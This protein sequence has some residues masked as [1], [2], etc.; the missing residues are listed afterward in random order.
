[1]A[2]LNNGFSA[3]KQVAHEEFVADTKAELD[4]VPASAIDALPDIPATQELIPTGEMQSQEDAS[5]ILEVNPTTEVVDQS[6][7]ITPE[8]LAEEVTSLKERVGQLEDQLNSPVVQKVIGFQNMLSRQLERLKQ[9]PQ[10]AT[11]KVDQAL[12][13]AG[14]QGEKLAGR[15][16]EYVSVADRVLKYAQAEMDALNRNSNFRVENGKRVPMSPVMPAMERPI[17]QL[18][19]ERPLP[20]ISEQ[21]PR[22]ESV[23]AA[24]VAA[25]ETV[26]ASVPEDEE[27]PSTEV[28]AEVLG[29]AVTQPEQIAATNKSEAPVSEERPEQIVS[30]ERGSERFARV[31]ELLTDPKC[32]EFVSKAAAFVKEFNLSD[33]ATLMILAHQFGPDAEIVGAL[34]DHTDGL[35]FIQ[36]LTQLDLNAETAANILEDYMGGVEGFQ[37]V[38]SPEERQRAEF[39]ELIK[40]GEGTTNSGLSLAAQRYSYQAEEARLSEI[41]Q[42]GEVPYLSDRQV[43]ESAPGRNGESNNRELLFVYA[44]EQSGQAA[45]RNALQHARLESMLS[46]QIMIANE[47]VQSEG[48]IVTVLQ[49]QLNQALGSDVVDV[50][51]ERDSNGNALT[52]YEPGKTMLLTDYS[53]GHLAVKLIAVRNPEVDSRQLSS[54]CKL[55]L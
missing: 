6:N 52:K 30:N 24:T 3:E 4:P 23:P 46:N 14:N 43:K 45:V 12:G 36:G 7:P 28:V 53:N 42:E 34:L 8:M 38:E 48:D 29:A 10:A 13:W 1:M 47:K 16:N 17:S 22:S 32:M 55:N 54:T 44:G 15:V 11:D 33:A 50:S 39:R 35:E 25:A 20:D 21:I 9:I 19:Q 40:N 51:A 31:T 37:Q 2:A 49:E 18:Q 5:R 41:L 26:V 27:A